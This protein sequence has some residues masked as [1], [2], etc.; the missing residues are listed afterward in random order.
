MSKSSLLNF[1]C[2]KR[3]VLLLKIKASREKS[4]S[5]SKHGGAIKMDTH[6]IAKYT[7]QKGSQ[8]GLKPIPEA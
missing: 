8:S 5:Y 3:F 1:G 2:P 6:I 4:L 7:I